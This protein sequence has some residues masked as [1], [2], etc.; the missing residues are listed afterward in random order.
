MKNLILVFVTAI[1]FCF[2]NVNAQSKF[3]KWP[4]LKTFHGVMSQTFH[5]SEE[6][7]LQPIKSRIAEF[8]EKANALA[9]SKIPTEFNNKSVKSATQKLKTDSKKLQK[10]ILKNKSDDEIK[11]SLSA[12]HDTFHLIVEKCVKGDGHEH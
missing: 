10:I 6:G 9:K 11:K 7:N 3:D 8:V 5:P 1:L 2:Q 12:L 4:E